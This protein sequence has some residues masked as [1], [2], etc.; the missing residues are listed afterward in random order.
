MDREAQVS[1]EQS[2]RQKLEHSELHEAV[3]IILEGYGPELFTYLLRTTHNE[4]DASDVFSEFCE[5]L[6]CG[7]A[8]FQGR[9][10]C[11]TWL[12][13]M[14]TNTRVDFLR[15]P[16]HRRVQR[17]ETD[18]MLKLEQ[19]VRSRTLSYL[20][21]EVVDRFA[22]LHAELDREEQTLL[23]LRVEKEMTWPEI[24]EVL[25]GPDE[26]LSE[27]ELPSRAAAL[28]QR[29]KRLKEKI[30]KIAREE[31]LLENS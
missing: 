27:E 4:A 15:N 17:L 31:G 26:L 12:Y 8:T 3:R 28:R 22:K 19:Q 21:S 14:A 16:N 20:R 7:I 25:R 1:L 13:R 24:A 18:E 23:L 10:A 30:R 9:S 11:R 29:F 6:W 5:K 2:I